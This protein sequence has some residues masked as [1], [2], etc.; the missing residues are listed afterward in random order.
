MIVRTWTARATPENA[1]KYADFF[2]SVLVPQLREIDGHHGAV[3]LKRDNDG[4]AEIV[5]VTYWE[6]YSAIDSFACDD[7][8][9]AV[10]ESDAAALLLDY[11]KR[12][13]HYDAVLDT[14]C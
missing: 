4:V 5:V 13:T 6:S 1:G 9:A 2:A 3:V 14:R 11:D 8:E 7:R 10:V 12:V